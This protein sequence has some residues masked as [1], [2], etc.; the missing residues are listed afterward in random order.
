MKAS[1]ALLPLLLILNAC[2]SIP[3]GVSGQPSA[4]PSS[5]PVQISSITSKP[6]PQAS[7]IPIPSAPPL[8]SSDFGPGTKGE[9]LHDPPMPII[10][11][12]L[13][14]EGT[15]FSGRVYD[16]RQQAIQTGVVTAQSLN[17]NVP[18][19]ASTPIVDGVY[20]FNRT[21][22]GVQ[23]KLTVS[24]DGY[25]PRSRYIVPT[26]NKTGDPNANHFDF[27]T[28]PVAIDPA[29]EAALT[30][31]PEVTAGRLILG[32]DFAWQG[33]ALRFSEP[34]ERSSVENSLTVF[35]PDSPIDS[36]ERNGFNQAHFEL[37]WNDDD[38]ELTLMFKGGAASV[39]PSL[40]QEFLMT[41]NSAIQDKKGVTRSSEFFRTGTYAETQI[42]LI[43]FSREAFPALEK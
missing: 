6:S 3:T 2:Q 20:Q 18:Y 4:P 40:V 34:M 27:G 22:T 29:P 10:A 21:P 32:E 23:I 41:F 17:Q 12:D 35:H 9:K 8:L 14:M 30:D 36:T 15:Q 39:D 19:E 11:P 13:A 33:L 42:P 24:T 25:A 7:L 31:R 43:R 38:T 37:S 16:D 5:L 1:F 28:G 26:S